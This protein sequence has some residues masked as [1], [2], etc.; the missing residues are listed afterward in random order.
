[1][2]AMI[3]SRQPPIKRITAMRWDPSIALK[4]AMQIKIAPKITVMT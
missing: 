1:M 4:K 3:M 2:P